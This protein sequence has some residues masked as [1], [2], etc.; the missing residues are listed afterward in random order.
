MGSTHHDLHLSF[1]TAKE[2]TIGFVVAEAQS[3]IIL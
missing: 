1:Y 3:T 2:K